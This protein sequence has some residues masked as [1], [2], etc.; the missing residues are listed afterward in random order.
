VSDRRVT[1]SGVAPDTAR[2]RDIADGVARAAEATGFDAELAIAAGPRALPY[3]DVQGMLASVATCGPLAVAPPTAGETFALGET[4]AVTGFVGAPAD[5]E[6]VSAILR[7]RIG[8][9]TPSTDLVVLDPDM[10]ALVDLLPVASPGPVSLVLGWGDRAGPNLTGIY[11]PGENPT[12][13][14]RLP[15][16]VDGHLWVAAL[17]V[18]GR[19]FNI[20]PTASF[21]DSRISG[22]GAVAAG[23]RTIRVAHSLAESAADDRKLSIIARDDSGK[24]MIIAFTSDKPLFDGLREIND[25]AK[26]FGS[27]LLRNLEARGVTV[28]SISTAVLDT[29]A[30]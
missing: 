5:V 11:A 12:I 8:D 17:D 14:V 24:S 18:G 22:L 16:D 7:D 15:A 29:R 21:P 10:C 23:V 4:V 3:R 26:S 2:R 6:S 28:R 27:D 1:V 19:L 20:L 13:D 25:T 30:R 9:R